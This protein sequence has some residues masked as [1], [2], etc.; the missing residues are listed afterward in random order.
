MKKLSIILGLFLVFSSLTQAF[1]FES[2]GL[3]IEE[4]LILGNTRTPDEVIL[5]Q[6]PFTLGDDWRETFVTWTIN[7]LITLNIFAYHPL[8]I[9]TEPLG[10]GTCRVIIRVK[11]PHILF[12]DPAEYA[13][14]TG[15][16][17]IFSN[18]RQTL[19]N[20]LGYGQ[21]LGVFI[22]WGEYYHYEGEIST[23]LGPG[24]FHLKAFDYKRNR[25]FLQHH[26]ESREMGGG[27][28]YRYWWNEHWRQTSSLLYY[29][30]TLNGEEQEILYPS[31]EFYYKGDVRALFNVKTGLTGHPHEE[32]P[33]YKAEG[34]LFGQHG[35]LLGLLR[36]GIASD[37]TP[38][39]YRF[40]VGGFS[41]LPLRGES[42]RRLTTSYL[43][44]TGEYHTSFLGLIPL[45]FMDL[46]WVAKDESK[47]YQLD[48]AIINMGIG[49]AIETP[50]GL[51]VRFDV[52]TNPEDWKITW[53]IGFGHTFSSPF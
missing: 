14:S 5:K 50:L 49:I 17:L 41:S 37:N 11:D 33:F 6:L 13:F 26:Y 25:F 35:P 52:A 24:V 46:G 48:D 53:N 9:V 1:A 16:G 43:M 39:N 44:V 2:E 45:I 3:I 20:P 30:N 32:E 15:I 42:I 4:I 21:N 28:S 38:L 36:G 7:R 40:P 22:N 19:Y 23:P 34:V 12:K 10:E 8:S 31:L 47:P 29:N 51:P 27:I 18:L